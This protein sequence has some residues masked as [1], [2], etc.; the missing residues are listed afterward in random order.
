MPAV[1]VRLAELS[2]ISPELKPA[3]IAMIP[4]VITVIAISSSSSPKPPSLVTS[5]RSTD[6]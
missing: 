6:D 4:T 1:D 5:R 3:T 2:A